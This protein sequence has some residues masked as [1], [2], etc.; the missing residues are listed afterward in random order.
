MIDEK[1]FEKHFKPIEQKPDPGQVMVR[2]RASAEFINGW[3]KRNV[4]E[5][6]GSNKNGVALSKSIM[7]KLVHA[8]ETKVLKEMAQDLWDGMTVDQVAEKPYPIVVQH[9][10]WAKRDV[11]PDDPHWSIIETKDLRLVT[12]EISN[13]KTPENVL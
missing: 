2:W 5:L 4:I 13:V 9:F 8:D 3:I 12:E 11:V 6:L 10:Y 1:D 7:R